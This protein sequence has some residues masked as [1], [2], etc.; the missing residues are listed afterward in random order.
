MPKEETF[1]DNLT[2]LQGIID[3]LESGS[4]SLKKMMKL[5]EEGMQLMTICRS[6]LQE[7]EERIT[8]LIKQNDKLI[9]KPG[10]DQS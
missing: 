9:E 8:T 1:E 4:P 2:N 3:E 5:F 7:V 10:I 6:N